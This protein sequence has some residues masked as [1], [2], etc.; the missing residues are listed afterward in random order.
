[1]F[2]RSRKKLIAEIIRLIDDEG[3]EYPEAED[4]A[5]RSFTAQPPSGGELV[6]MYDAA[7]AAEEGGA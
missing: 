6:R 4:R 3:F 7:R 2:I 1:M 5:L